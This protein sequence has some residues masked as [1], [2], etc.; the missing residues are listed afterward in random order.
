MS[1]ELTSRKIY[2]RN[3]TA[4]ADNW[5]KG[6]P[7]TAR[8]ESGVDNSF[9]GLEFDQRNLDKR[10][11]PG[12]EFEYHFGTPPILRRVEPEKASKPIDLTDVD[13][14]GALILY[15]LFGT[16][17]SADTG[18]IIREISLEDSTQLS[19]WRII[20]DLE[21]GHVGILLAPFSPAGA[22]ELDIVEQDE[23]DA[24][25]RGNVDLISRDNFGKLRFAVITGNRVD[26]L[27]EDGVINPSYYEPGDLTRSLC[28]PWQYDFADCGCFYWAS[29]KPDMVAGEPDGDQFYNFQRRRDPATEPPKGG[30]GSTPE[31]KS[32][33][34]TIGG[35]DEDTLRHRE[36]IEK[37]EGLPIVLEV[38]EATTFNPIEH[39][40]LPLDQVL[41]RNEVITRL[42]Y[43]ATVEHALMVE[44]LYAYYS[45]NAPRN[46][47]TVDGVEARHYDAANTV[48]S[49]AIDE[50]RHFRWV[51]E[52][53][54]EL[55]EGTII[56]RAD[57]FEDVDQDNRHL[58]HNFSLQALT[59]DRLSWFI[60]VEK[61]S[62]EVD[63][64]LAGDTVDGL[65]TRLLLS[66]RQ[67]AD[68]TDDEKARLLHLIKLII[69]EGFDHY[70]RFQNVQ[71]V[72]AGLSPDDYLRL[73]G[74]PERLNAGHPGKVAE[75]TADK[76]Y[77]VVLSTLMLVF[78]QSNVNT[79]DLLQAARFAMY[80]LDDAIRELIQLG[81]APLFT[82]PTFVSG[83]DAANLAT[84]AV[85]TIGQPAKVEAYIQDQLLKDIEPLL[86]GLRASGSVETAET[87]AKRYGGLKDALIDLLK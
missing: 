75:L 10:F 12:L 15:K 14:G 52:I 22:P 8:P 51:N 35:W 84:E 83:A 76:A 16:F 3:L 45:I 60:D 36:M 61:P 47:P 58:E 69:D 21:P 48:L 77:S 49:I 57:A 43:L 64:S 56:D 26:Y 67:S 1:K 19:A 37:W 70:N 46:R 50:M 31:E 38:T 72:L 74:E 25:L 32:K 28:A 82:L 9:P 33:F 53:L 4:L 27:S 44:Y 81:G 24:A 87:M 78:S 34:Q 55:N 11:F 17:G 20:H 23:A 13:V 5:Q 59:E 66:I 42:K 62:K 2:P 41:S 30:P 73:D 40:E 63:P 39:T 29:N 65:Y 54:R 18:S 71:G 7:V 80:A 79:G 6:N 68:F 86:D 85:G